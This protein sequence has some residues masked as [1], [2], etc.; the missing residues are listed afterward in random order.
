MSFG[1]RGIGSNVG[2]FFLLFGSVVAF[3]FAMSSLQ[4]S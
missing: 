2:F 1:T 3:T 4:R